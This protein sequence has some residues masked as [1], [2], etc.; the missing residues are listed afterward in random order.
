MIQNHS[1][2]PSGRRLATFL[3]AAFLFAV[4]PV[5]T[6]SAQAPD[7]SAD[8]GRPA[9]DADSDA[10]GAVEPG[11][12][13]DP[14]PVSE[15]ETPPT[16]A[17]PDPVA[18]LDAPPPQAAAAPAASGHDA[19]AAGDDEAY[20]P[21][22]RE[23]EPLD[24]VRLPHA[25]AARPLVLPHLVGR[26]RFQSSGGADDD[27][28]FATVAS[29]VAVGIADVAEIG[30]FLP[31]VRLFPLPTLLDPAVQ[32][33]V[34]FHGGRLESG[35]LVELS[36]PVTDDSAVVTN[37]GWRGYLHLSDAARIDASV[38]FGVLYS[39]P[40][41]T[42]LRVPVGITVSPSPWFSFGV[43]SGVDVASFDKVFIPLELF[44]A[45]ST[46]R[47]TGAA[48]DFITFFTLPSA[49]DGL[50]IWSLTLAVQVHF[51]A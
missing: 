46:R 36:A 40:T 5:A 27:R 14:P 19:P 15:P 13:P 32:G 20:D 33:L 16:D 38:V 29:S 45:T 9:P 23:P 47:R 44:I 22:H 28:G 8:A 30:V 49:T 25:L 43:S 50:E 37:I 2:R 17:S 42:Q 18:P 24:A 11:D 35:V 10:A 7:G 34:R 21:G 39:D 6:V 1:N 4:L 31:T 51:Y 48:I 3:P 12:E 26:L 41:R